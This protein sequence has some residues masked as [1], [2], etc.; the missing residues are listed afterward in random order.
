PR[1]RPQARRRRRDRRRAHRDGGAARVPG[2]RGQAGRGRRRR[3]QGRPGRRGRLRRLGRRPARPQPGTAARRSAAGPAGQ[4]R[5]RRPAG[6]ARG[7]GLMVAITST[8]VLNQVTQYLTAMVDVVADHDPDDGD[9]VTPGELRRFLGGLRL[10]EGVPFSYLVPDA[11]L[12]PLESI[13]FFYLD[14]ACTDAMTQGVLGVG[15]VT[16]A[17]RAQLEAMYPTIRDE[18]DE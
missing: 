12:L 14:R 3:A 9:H 11:R 1:H 2:R 16:T 13:R 4:G 17:D 8:V 10:L 7:G 6:R 15:T 18:V 5:P